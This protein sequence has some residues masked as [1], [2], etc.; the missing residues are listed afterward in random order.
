[1]EDRGG[2]GEE[3]QRAL[4]DPPTRY[5]SFE[6]MHT[7]AINTPFSAVSKGANFAAGMGK[8]V[9]DQ[10]VGVGRGLVSIGIAF[11]DFLLNGEK[12]YCMVASC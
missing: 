1:M 11:R 5:V 8:N 4:D 3:G 12:F 9:L 10:G 6:P 7:S 2:K